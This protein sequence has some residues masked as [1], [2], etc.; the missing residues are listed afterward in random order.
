MKNTIMVKR[1]KSTPPST[2]QLFIWPGLETAGGKLGLIQGFNQVI[3]LIILQ[4]LYI[5]L[6]I[7]SK[8]THI[9]ILECS[10]EIALIVI[11]YSVCLMYK[12]M[13]VHIQP[14]NI[15]ILHEYSYI[16]HRTMFSCPWN[17]YVSYEK[18]LIC[19]SSINEFVIL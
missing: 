10:A 16:W 18:H 11:Q 7:A 19:L 4:S 5:K 17:V 15:Y 2:P 13:C 9:H 12:Y 14:I 1:I 8:N 6:E 3:D